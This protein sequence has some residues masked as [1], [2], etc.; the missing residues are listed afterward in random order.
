MSGERPVV[1]GVPQGSVLG[2]LLFLIFVNHLPY[3][4]RSKCK[5]FADDLK[6][7]MKIRHGCDEEM[8]ADLVSCQSDID[9]LCCVSSSWGLI[10]NSEK[11]VSI[12]FQRGFVDWDRVGLSD[13]SLYG[14]PIQKVSSH[15]DLGVIVDNKLKFHEHIRS[16]VDKASGLS[17]NIL[18]STLCR[19]SS[20][21]MP[22]FLAHIRPLIEFGSCVWN[23]GYLG[24]LR[25]LEGV[26]RR[27][28]KKI[29]GLED[30]SYLSR[31]RYLN[32][33]SV[34]GRLLRAD[35]VKCWKIF[36]GKCSIDPSELFTFPTRG[37]TR[38]HKYKL[39]H[40]NSRL[41]CRLR[42]FSVRIVNIWNDLPCGVVELESLSAF[43]SAL[44]VSLGDVLFDF[45]D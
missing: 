36:H 11:C 21:M 34:K 42:S 3:Y 33:F 32:L 13:Y 10:L 20:F 29:R 19:D 9:R 6:I 5:I 38:G 37:G 44:M 14:Q 18:R 16:V 1:C 31:L 4:I 2:P 7:Y 27:W 17:A 41:E 22:V 26:Q 12:R 25:L 24:D 43:K 28:T 15:R 35:L 45:V 39:A 40:R 30:M 23:T 8:S